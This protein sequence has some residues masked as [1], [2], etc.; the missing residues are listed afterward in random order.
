MD[1]PDEPLSGTLPI[2]ERQSIGEYEFRVFTIFPFR[3]FTKTPTRVIYI[4]EVLNPIKPMALNRPAHR[5]S[6]TSYTHR[7]L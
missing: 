6:G 5:V 2:S 7:T 3:V 1:K 4:Y